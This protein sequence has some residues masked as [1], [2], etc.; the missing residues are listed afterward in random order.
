MNKRH[1]IY[2]LRLGG[3]LPNPSSEL[4]VETARLSGPYG[5]AKGG[6]G[7]GESRGFGLK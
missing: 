6:R 5:P 4:V 7:A 2:L 3:L 1:S